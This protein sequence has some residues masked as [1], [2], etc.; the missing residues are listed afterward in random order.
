MGSCLVSTA[1]RHVRSTQKEH[2]HIHMVNPSVEAGPTVT[3]TRNEEN[4]RR[5]D[6]TKKMVC[7]FGATL[8]CKGWLVIGQHGGVLGQDHH[9]DGERSCTRETS[10]DRNS[11]IQSRKLLRQ[12]R[13][14]QTRRNVLVKTRSG[15]H[16]NLQTPE[17]HNNTTSTTSH[18]TQTQHTH[19]TLPLSLRRERR[20]RDI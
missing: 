19:Q 1:F 20:A 8:G 14:E 5:I 16:K 7:E 18:N 2:I 15:R 17:A 9:T 3:K 13:A 11:P 10:G 6:V 4:G 12:V